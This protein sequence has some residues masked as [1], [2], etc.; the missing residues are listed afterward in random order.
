M[1]GLSK[2][3][4]F[5]TNKKGEKVDVDSMDE[6]YL[7]N[8]VKFLIRSRNSDFVKSPSDIDDN[9]MDTYWELKNSDYGDRD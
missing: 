5:W 2:N 3:K 6:T 9:T 1:S 4:V 8:L 7:R